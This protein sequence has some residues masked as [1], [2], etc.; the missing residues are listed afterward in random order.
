LNNL[1]AI[2]PEAA[3]Q[4][5]GLVTRQN[6]DNAVQFPS[7]QNT[8]VRGEKV[9]L[10]K[11]PKV[12][13]QK[14]PKVDLIKREKVNLIKPEKV[15]LTKPEKVNLIKSPKVDLMKQ[16]KVDLVKRYV[17]SEI[18]GETPKVNLIKS[19]PMQRL[20]ETRPLGS[21]I[22]ENSTSPAL[23]MQDFKQQVERPEITVTPRIN[24]IADTITTPVVDLFIRPQLLPDKPGARVQ[25]PIDV[26]IPSLKTN[27][28]RIALGTPQTPRINLERVSLIKP[29]RV[30]SQQNTSTETIN[31]N[32]TA[33]TEVHLPFV[34]TQNI[35]KKAEE[36]QVLLPD[37]T[38][39][40]KLQLAREYVRKD[41]FKTVAEAIT[42]IE[43]KIQTEPTILN[44][45]VQI[46]ESVTVLPTV[47]QFDGG[48]NLQPKLANVQE[49]K[50]ILQMKHSTSQEVSTTARVSVKAVEKVQEKPQI[51]AKVVTQ[52]KESTKIK[53]ANKLKSAAK[54]SRDAARKMMFALDERAQ[55]NRLRS[56]YDALT[57]VYPAWQLEYKAPLSTVAAKLKAPDKE[58][59]SALIQQL[60]KSIDGSNNSMRDWRTPLLTSN[61]LLGPIDARAVGEKVILSIRPVKVVEEN[62]GAHAVTDSDVEL[63]L[64]GDM[65]SDDRPRS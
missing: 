34:V 59:D 57:N 7:F 29:E 51:A 44:K 1:K 43:K 41:K 58:T 13:L 25:S 10:I 42:F 3:K 2:T 9:N 30:N 53:I 19:P 16:P 26:Q 62:Q 56:W 61:E 32:G 35:E 47:K 12:D 39:V 50:A 40:Q 14:A 55:R 33:N 31:T 48:Q 4:P 5:Q 37:A 15:D 36:K 22:K 54:K 24:R 38:A 18:S 11:S 60:G 45:P 27:S 8:A 23:P 20:P 49:A 64:A 28:E 17:P 21:L 46:T 6:L 63:V 52:T 65:Q